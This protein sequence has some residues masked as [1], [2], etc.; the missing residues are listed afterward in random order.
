MWVKLFEK[1]FSWFGYD[2]DLKGLD[3]LSLNNEKLTS[4]SSYANNKIYGNDATTV[5][6]SLDQQLASKAVIEI[7]FKNTNNNAIAR[8]LAGSMADQFKKQNIKVSYT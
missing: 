2:V 3:Y 1:I 5:R 7:D 4:A 8:E 6:N